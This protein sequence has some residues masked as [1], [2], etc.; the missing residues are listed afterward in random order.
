MENISRGQGGGWWKGEKGNGISENNLF[1][2]NF[3]Y[4]GTTTLTVARNRNITGGIGGAVIGDRIQFQKTTMIN[5]H[6]GG[7][8]GAV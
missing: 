3:T 7:V 2:E 4:D 1:W 6:A 8:V 5:N